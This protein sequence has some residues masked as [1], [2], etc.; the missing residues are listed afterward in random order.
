MMAATGS[1]TVCLVVTVGGKPEPIIFTIRQWKPVRIYFVVSPG[2]QNYVP[3]ILKEVGNE[4]PQDCHEL[5]RLSNPEDLEKTYGELRALTR[6]LEQWIVS[7]PS[8]NRKVVFD[9]TGGTKV[10][11]AALALIATSIPGSLLSYVGGERAEFGVGDVKSGAERLTCVPNPLDSFAIKL[12]EAGKL[13]ISHHAF[14]AAA[15]LLQPDQAKVEKAQKKQLNALRSLAEALSDW[16][17]FNHTD[18]LQKLNRLED[19]RNDFEAALGPADT[20]ALFV[21]IE[22]LRRFLEGIVTNK[23]TQHAPQRRIVDLIANGQRRLDEGRFDDATA[24]FYRAIEAIGQMHLATYD[25]DT[26]NVDVSKI[27]PSCRRHLPAAEGNRIAIGLYAA[28]ELLR[29]L[30]EPNASTFFDLCGPQNQSILSVRNSSILAHGFTPMSGPGCEKLRDLVLR[31]AGV[32]LS[33][34][35]QFAWPGVKG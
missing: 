4:I 6:T 29:C 27:P 1:A 18:A 3:T 34:L 33:D 31:L 28:W 20:A 8:A 5:C 35:P 13:L 22:R 32:E 25:I 21:A 26:S 10:M 2:S 15:R 23:E 30:G 19:F 7:G 17:L 14:A 11:S 16:D 9:V 12:I 24:R